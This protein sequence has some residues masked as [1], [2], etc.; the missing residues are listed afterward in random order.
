[1]RWHYGGVV[2]LTLHMVSTDNGRKEILLDD[3][4]LALTLVD[5]RDRA[6]LLWLEAAFTEAEKTGAGA[7]V[8]AAQADVMQ[9]H[10][11]MPC[12][13]HRREGCD[14]FAAFRLKLRHLAAK[15]ARPVLFVHG[16]TNPY[17]LDRAF[18]G[19]AAP[20]L[21]RLNSTGDFALV[22]AAEIRVN[23]KDAA[24]PFS[25]I[26]LTERKPPQDRCGT[27]KPPQ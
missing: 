18:G 2:F 19:A 1:M 21:W 14:A 8:I 11:D 6:N 16:D 12:G 3:K 13:P 23:L 4:E 27:R 7:I 25:V 22:D 5:A 9:H 24:A 15:F 10:S 17:C 26:S 20:K